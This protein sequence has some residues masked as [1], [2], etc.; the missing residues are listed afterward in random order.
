MKPVR[1]AL[2]LAAVL[3]T[4]VC[5][6]APRSGTDLVMTEAGFVPRA[7]PVDPGSETEAVAYYDKLDAE[8][9]PQPGFTFDSFDT[10]LAYLGYP[11]LTGFDVENRESAALMAACDLQTPVPF[12]ACEVLA[13]RFFA[14]K[15]TDVAVNGGV[16]TLG[17]RKL[18]R[19]KARKGSGA[20]TKGIASA[21]LLFNVFSNEDN[22]FRTKSQNNQVMFVRA[23]GAPLE[24]PVYWLVY[25]AV[26]RVEGN[27]VVKA[28]GRR[29][30]YLTA[31]FDA[32]AKGVGEA[33]A[34]NG[35]V[36]DQRY[37]V[38][39]ACAHC[40]GGL[41]GGEADFP[42]AKLNYLDTDHWFDR[43]Q[44]GDDFSNLKPG[45]DVVL[46]GLTPDPHFPND[47]TKA[48]TVVGSPEFTRAFSVIRWL[49]NEIRAQNTVTK[50]GANSFQFRAVD[51]WFALHRQTDAHVDMFERGIA[52]GG[53]QWDRANPIDEQLLPRLNRYCF[54]CHSSIK[55]HVFDKDAV[56]LKAD[57]MIELMKRDVTNIL[58]MPQDRD[59]SAP[60]AAAR[61]RACL[62]ELLDRVGQNVP[63]KC[64]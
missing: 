16:I 47:P 30:A 53:R 22:P 38:P 24:H 17:W 6:K 63:F 44:K 49:N 64:Q 11:E 62:L 40:H 57:K 10:V 59:M 2:C 50:G 20:E 7:A 60:P 52:P 14:P 26:S 12:S 23:T 29:I 32:R 56:V 34:A 45:T 8:L 21:W 5:T 4:A 27:A 39:V 28:D 15:I 31:S 35:V 48:R 18:V 43:T 25:E 33:A 46:D 13:T 9:G 36:I 42:A 58:A 37:Y 19:L 55:Y 54:R 61:D 1:V 41:T 51:K 3:L